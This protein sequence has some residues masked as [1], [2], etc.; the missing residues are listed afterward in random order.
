MT[1]ILAVATNQTYT[2]VGAGLDAWVGF[3][4]SIRLA[5]RGGEKYLPLT[6]GGM[7]IDTTKATSYYMVH[8]LD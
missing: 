7:F 4:K 8:V 3:A 5:T 1:S 6:T 2:A